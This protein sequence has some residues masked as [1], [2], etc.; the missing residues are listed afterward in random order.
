MKIVL[1]TNVLVSALLRPGSLPSRVVDLVLARQVTLAFDLRIFGEYQEVLLRPEFA[2]PL[3]QVSDLMKFLW[4]VG[5]RVQ[6]TPLPLRLPD[7]DDGMFI[8]VA[9]S[10]LADALVT[11]NGK[12]FPVSQRHGVCVLSP[13]EWLTVWA[14]RESADE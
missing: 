11:G 10:A 9:V 2:F 4:S 6:A 12:H 1:D 7:Q 14:S 5:E 8:E 3:H 13:R